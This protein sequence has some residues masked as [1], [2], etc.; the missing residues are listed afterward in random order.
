MQLASE[1]YNDALTFKAIL[2]GP[3][4]R[5]GKNVTMKH[6]FFTMVLSISHFFVS[7]QITMG[8]TTGLNFSKSEFRSS[9]VDLKINSTTN[10]FI[11]LSPSI[12]LGGILALTTDVLYSRRGYEFAPFGAASAKSRYHFI[13]VVPYLEF[14]I[15]GPLAVTAGVHLGLKIDEEKRIGDSDW[16]DTGNLEEINKSDFGFNLG[17]K[18]RLGSLAVFVRYNQGLVDVLD[19]VFTDADGDNIDDVKQYL[20]FWQ[21]GVSFRL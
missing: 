16:I 7:G 2:F 14:G 17:A 9:V 4:T 11:G 6:I 12:S 8:I 10:Y 21:L 1:V 15:F 18:V 20:H 3:D 5:F 13:D 19:T